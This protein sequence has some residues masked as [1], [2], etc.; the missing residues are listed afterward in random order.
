MKVEVIKKNKD[1]IIGTVGELIK[2]NKESYRVLIGGLC[3]SHQVTLFK[4]YSKKFRNTSQ[5]QLIQK[6]IK[7][8]KK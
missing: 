3:F 2:E 6:I 1:F 5:E 7:R 8:L 4:M